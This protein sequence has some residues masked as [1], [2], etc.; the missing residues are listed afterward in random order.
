MVIEK[1]ASY[2]KTVGNTKINMV[3]SI[4]VLPNSPMDVDAELSFFT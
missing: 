3:F 1:N 2:Y 4:L